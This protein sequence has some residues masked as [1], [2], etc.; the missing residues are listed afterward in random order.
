[1]ALIKNGAFADDTWIDA[2]D[3]D[4]LTDQATVVSL[5][6]WQSETDALKARNAPLGLRLDAGE[7][8]EAI[9]DDVDQF[10]LIKLNFPAFKDG[11][12]YSYARML[13]QRYG[14]TRELRA[15]GNVLRSQLQ[16]MHRVG[17]DAFQVDD[18]ITPEVYAEEVSK[19]HEVY[20]PSAD[21][22]HTVFDKRAKK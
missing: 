14:Y 9:A 22:E 16:F 10:D 20:Q 15:T 6:R 1:M 4:A 13:R 8:P 3:D 12:A 18:R 19:L 7:S 2:N 21:D 17:F 5:H 11:R